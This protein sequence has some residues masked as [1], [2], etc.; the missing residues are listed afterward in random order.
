MGGKGRG[1]VRPVDLPA[2]AKKKAA[3]DGAPKAKTL[4]TLELEEAQMEKLGDILE[5]RH[6]YLP[7]EVDYARFAYK[8][9]KVNVVAYASGKLVVQGKRTEDFVQNILEAEVTGDPRMGYEEF[10]HPEW[11]EPHG[12]LDESGKGDLFGPLVSACVLVT[13]GEIVKKWREAGVQDSKKIGEKAALQLDKMIRATKGAVVAVTFAGM[14]RYNAIMARPGANLNQYLAWLHAKSLAQALEKERVPWALIDQFSK[15]PLTQDIVKKTG[16]TI[17]LRMRTKAESDPV[18]AAASIVASAEFTRQ[19]AKLGETAGVKLL[20][21]AGAGVKAQAV[22]IFEKGGRAVLE[23]VAKMHFK[24]AYEAMGLTPP[25]KP[26]FGS[27][28]GKGGG[29]ERRDNVQP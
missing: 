8:G 15:K 24:T 22:E 19:L 12:G 11:F 16:E 14:E 7:H 27:W 2:M 1:E 18:V 13:D 6:D 3:D 23:S 20:K 28:R 17:D 9:E 25:Q 29:G 21:G 5:G 4:Y 10:H 26:A